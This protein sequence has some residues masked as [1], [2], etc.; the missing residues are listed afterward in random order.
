MKWN[1]WDDPAY[2]IFEGSSR[3][4]KRDYKPKW[5]PTDPEPK[6][7]NPRQNRRDWCDRQKWNGDWYRRRRDVKRMCKPEPT[8]KGLEEQTNMPVTGKRYRKISTL[9]LDD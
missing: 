4:F 2:E 8:L 9:N 3:F 6:L 7:K 5:R 1:P